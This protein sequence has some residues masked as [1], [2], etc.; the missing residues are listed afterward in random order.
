MQNE[1]RVYLTLDR[2]ERQF[3]A[4]L[5]SPTG[6]RGY[7][8][9]EGMSSLILE[10]APGLAIERVTDTALKAAPEL[11]P[12][13][14]VVERQFGV[15]E[16][17]AD[18]PADL[19]RAGEAILASLGLRAEDQL[20]PEILVM[21]VVE[22]I[23]DRHAVIINRNKQASMVLPGESMLLLELVPALFASYAAN[24]AEKAVPGIRL[25]DLRMIGATG[26]L[27]LSGSRDDVL[28][29]AEHIKVKLAAI[30][31]RGPRAQKSR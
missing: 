8:P 14:L 4:Y 31:G 15:L 21:D 26:R 5:S 12:G 10:I 1:L 24:E 16:V 2:L 23:T 22:D 20:K 18:Q 9:L 28:A 30:P 13:L 3:A 17:H 11:E 6:G 29:A 7:V 27:Y 19:A 25:V